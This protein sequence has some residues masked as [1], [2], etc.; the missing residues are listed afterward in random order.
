MLV[1]KGPDGDIEIPYVEVG[2]RADIDGMVDAAMGVGRDGNPVERVVADIR[3]AMRGVTLEPQV[4]FDQELV[5]QRI[6]GYVGLLRLDPSDASVSAG[7]EGYALTP[8]HDGRRGD[9]TEAIN[10]ALATLG[11]VDAP[12]RLELPVPMTALPPATTT[13]E[14]Q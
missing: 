6:S 2:R 10:T 4:V 12:P 3:T 8:G 7:D 5:E 11:R 14:A 13:V 9:P 1:L